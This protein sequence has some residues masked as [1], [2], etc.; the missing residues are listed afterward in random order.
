MSLL[1]WFGWRKRV[2]LGLA[3]LAVLAIVLLGLP[4][5]C[6]KSTIMLPMSDGVKLATDI[7]QPSKTGPH[8]VVLIRTPYNK[9]GLESGGNGLAA[10]GIVT[11]VQDSRGRYASEG[12][13]LPFEGDGWWGPTDGL[14]TLTW[15]SKQP[16]CN[17]KIA[18][19][20]GSALGICQL[21]L[22]GTG[23]HLIAAQQITVAAPSMYQ[24]MVYSGGVF[25]KSMIG[26]WLK[27]TNM[28]A[29]ALRNWTSHDL[30]DTYW[31]TRD[32][33]RR[34]E[35]AHAPAVHIGGWYD[36]FSQGTIDAFVG[37]QTLGGK[38]A[39][40]KQ[41]L[42]MGPWT[43]G[44]GQPKVGELTFPN[45]ATSPGKSMDFYS[46]IAQYLL[47]QDAGLEKEPAVAYYVMGDVTD[48]AAPGNVWRTADSWPP[49]KTVATPFYL[50]T[51]KSLS[52]IKP[53]SGKPLSYLSDPANPVPTVG[54][55]Q[56]TIPA[57]PM[58]QQ[59]IE[60][61]SD[62]LVFTSAPLDKPMEVTGKVRLKLYASVDATDTQ[63]IAR[64]CDVYPDGKSYNI[65]E[66]ALRASL[67]ESLSKMSLLKPGKPYMFDIDLWSTSIIFNKGHRLRVQVASTSNPGYASFPGD[68]SP[69]PPPAP[70][71]MTINVYVD[72]T[73]PSNI[74]LPVAR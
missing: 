62:M 48:K 13:N 14:D 59:S 68:G 7:Y 15:V 70:K 61:R 31:Q 21:D 64:F 27:S 46:M 51:D 40:G 53:A 52:T 28:D 67:R 22:A 6:D 9:A 63:F 4:G 60:G 41:K 36:I 18:T 57:G 42:V 38:G 65:C 47:G 66:G 54:G 34:Y 20:G 69:N 45:S 35:K 44:V 37:M 49:V 17:G 32:F 2:W 55:P 16:W 11:V 72:T 30:Y 8:P 19:Y 26:D 1:A 12:K 56:L 24:Y 74:V 10:A 39:R 50:T 71:P 3:G 33:T 73:H 23:T 25:R 29:Q 5:A 58:D 43:H